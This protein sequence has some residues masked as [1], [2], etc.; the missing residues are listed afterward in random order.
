MRAARG[1]APVRRGC[2]RVASAHPACA[3]WLRPRD[4]RHAAATVLAA[5]V[6]GRVPRDRDHQGTVSKE[7]YMKNTALPDLDHETIERLKQRFPDLSNIDLSKLDLPK[8]ETVGKNADQTIDRLLGRSRAPIWPWIAG[9][10]G[11]IAVIG[12]IAAYLAWFRRSPMELAESSTL[13]AQDLTSTSDSTNGTEPYGSVV[14]R[15]WPAETDSNV[16]VGTEEV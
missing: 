15:A 13:D 8:M 2:R 1:N 4:E 7:C 6:V 16:M 10:F 9:V 3:F 11:L 12:T 5:S 14:D